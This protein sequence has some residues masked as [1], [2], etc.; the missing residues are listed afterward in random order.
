MLLV[1]WG[2]APATGLPSGFLW[3]KQTAPQASPPH[4]PPS[5]PP[6]PFLSQPFSS[7][8]PPAPPR[9]VPPL[10]SEETFRRLVHW[11][12]SGPRCR[13]LGAEPGGRDR[14]GRERPGPGCLRPPDAPGPGSGAALTVSEP[15]PPG[16]GISAGRAWWERE[17]TSLRGARPGSGEGS[18]VCLLHPASWTA[19]AGLVWGSHLGRSLLRPTP[20]TSSVLGRARPE[21]GS[22]QPGPRS[23]TELGSRFLQGGS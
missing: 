14:T 20:S 18:R 7:P 23:A 21:E 9:P 12:V 5:H 15:G 4:P 1:A 2:R 19:K 17:A 13:G 8:P 22:P 11:P 16:W 6:L 10:S 3:G